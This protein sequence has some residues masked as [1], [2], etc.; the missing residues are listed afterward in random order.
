MK[1]PVLTLNIPNLNGRTY[2]QEAVDKAL[3]KVAGPIP[4]YRS[5]EEAIAARE[6]K[7]V[8]ISGTATLVREADKLVADI[9]FI[10]ADFEKQI[11]RGEIAVRPNG[12]GKIGEDGAISDYTI[13]S[14]S[15][16]NDPA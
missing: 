10:D 9:S 5:V 3:E 4:L 1:T 14:I 8:P 13:E 11:V 2:S 15:I 6:G 12:V 7:N 16:T